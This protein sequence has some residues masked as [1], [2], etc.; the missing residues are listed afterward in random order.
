MNE[1]GQLI[2]A[3]EE[4]TFD[5][6]IASIVGR[7]ENRRRRRRAISAAAGS[8]LVI[9]GIVVGVIATTSSPVQAY[10]SPIPATP[11]DTQ[12]TERAA[13]LCRSQ[14]GDLNPSPPPL[15]M[16]DQRADAA[17]A[18]FGGRSTGANGPRSVIST[19]TLIRDNGQWSAPPPDELPFQAFTMAGE[20]GEEDAAK[21]VIDQ[22]DGVRVEASLV[23]GYFHFWWPDTDSFPGG[24][25]RILDAEGNVLQ[26]H[27]VGT[28][29]PSEGRPPTT[30]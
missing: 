24:T 8:A 28:A 9:T 3:F 23:D 20:I 22:S 1:A 7:A 11:A 30:R 13:E 4:H 12:L 15:L 10:W 2:R 25:F 21:L 14:W 26:S 17:F 5:V 27:P 19:C 16:V 18:L 29:R 6:E